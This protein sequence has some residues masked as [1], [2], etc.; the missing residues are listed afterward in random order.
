MGSKAVSQR[1][2]TGRPGSG[3]LSKWMPL[4]LLPS[5]ESCNAQQGPRH[6]KQSFYIV[7]GGQTISAEGRRS[8]HCAVSQVRA[9]PDMASAPQQWRAVNLA[10]LF[11]NQYLRTYAGDLLRRSRERM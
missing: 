11:V 10:R 8:H 2:V 7:W 3:R 5:G 9:A 6:T 1:M 4:T